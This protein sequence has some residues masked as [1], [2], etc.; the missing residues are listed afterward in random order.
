MTITKIQAGKTEK[1]Y[2]YDLWIYRDLLFFLAWKDILVKYKQTVLGILWVLIRPLL[3]MIIFTIV[4]QK[5]AKFPSENVPYYIYVLIALVPWQFFSASFTES[6]ASLISNG[7]LISKVYFPR[8]IIPLST[9][10]SCFF[11]FLVSFILL[12]IVIYFSD[13][14]LKA[15]FFYL[16]IFIFL[17]FSVSLG[18]GL[19]AAALNLKFRDFRYII[20]F[21]IQM[22]LYASPVG[23]GSSVIPLKWKYF[24]SLNP[25]VGIIDGFRWCFLGSS[26]S[27]DWLVVLISSIISIL[28]LISGISFFRNTEKYFSDL[29]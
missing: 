4:F 19:W 5:I 3:I 17:L 25:L 8:I 28:I 18:F 26:V 6:G 2:F 27:F 20:P 23:F 29:L 14:N 10:V 15:Q 24:Y 22:G 13:I 21:V 9:L 1:T 7:N 16:P 11:D 12:L